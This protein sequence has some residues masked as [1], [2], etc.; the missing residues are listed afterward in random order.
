MRLLFP[1]HSYTKWASEVVETVFKVKRTCLN[2]GECNF[3][4]I[5]FAKNKAGETFAIVAGVSQFHKQYTSDICFY[6]INTNAEKKEAAKFMKK[7]KLS[8]DENE[9]LFLLNE[10]QDFRN[11]RES[12]DNEKKMQDDYKLFG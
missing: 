12:L 8:W 11:R 9:V 4:Y 1:L 6:D 7:N 3:S 2:S 5:K 10:N